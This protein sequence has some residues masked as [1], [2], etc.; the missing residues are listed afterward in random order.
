MFIDDLHFSP[1]LSLFKEK[2]REGFALPILDVSC[3]IAHGYDRHDLET[4][5]EFKIAGHLVEVFH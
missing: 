5:S 2:L 1:S 4:V 3:R